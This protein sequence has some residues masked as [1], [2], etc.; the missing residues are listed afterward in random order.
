MATPVLEL[1]GGPYRALL[2]DLDG[3]LTDTASLH[4]RAWKTVFDAFLAGWASAHQVDEPPFDPK[5]D[6][7]AYVDGRPRADGIR[8]FLAARGIVPPEG[9]PDDPPDTGT[10]TGLAR[11]KNAR[12]LA[13]LERHGVHVFPGSLALLRAAAAGGL[14]RAVV[15][16]SAN[17]RRVLAAAGLEHECDLVVDGN[18]LV[19][20]GLRGKPAPDT[21]LHAARR[22][23]VAPPEAVV[24][25]DA[26]AGVEAGRSGGFGLVVGVDRVGDAQELRA[27]GA[28]LVVVDLGELLVRQ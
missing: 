10:V 12:F 8:A 9:G 7:E 15:T 24:V 3:V 11:A 2:L 20:S 1:P 23:E 14:A 27:A 5:G 21:Y 16:S 6:Y 13:L 22:L 28:G 25:E 19:R 18:D 17:G 4:V 26:P